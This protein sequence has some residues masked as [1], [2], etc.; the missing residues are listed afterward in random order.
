MKQVIGEIIV[1][2]EIVERIGNAARQKVFADLTW[3]AKAK[4]ILSLYRNVLSE[5]SRPLKHINMTS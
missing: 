4:Q 5:P 3:E 2:P 1:H